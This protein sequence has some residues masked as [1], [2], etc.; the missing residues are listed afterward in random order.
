[1]SKTDIVNGLIVLGFN[2][3]NI[4]VIDAINET[5]EVFYFCN[6]VIRDIKICPSCPDIVAGCFASKIAIFNL[7]QKQVSHSIFSQM[8]SLS[9]RD[10]LF[11]LEQEQTAT[12]L[13]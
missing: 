13:R 11:K 9:G 1:M 7:Q 4:G 3:G 12:L 10:N 8:V 6:E 2:D 5:E